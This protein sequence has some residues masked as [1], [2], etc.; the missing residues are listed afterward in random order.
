MS[1]AYFGR[2]W[3][4]KGLL[5]VLFFSIIALT[6]MISLLSIDKTSE[7]FP[8]DGV[9]KH[10]LDSSTLIGGY[11]LSFDRGALSIEETR[12]SLREIEVHTFYCNYYSPYVLDTKRYV[13]LF[14]Y[15]APNYLLLDKKGMS[16]REIETSIPI[17]SLVLGK[18]GI[19]LV[20]CDSS[21]DS[22]LYNSKGRLMLKASFEAPICHAALSDNGKYVAF[23]LLS[24]NQSNHY[25]CQIFNVKTGNMIAKQSIASDAPPVCDY[26]GLRLTLWKNN[27]SEK[28]TSY[29]LLSWHD[30]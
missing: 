21:K 4:R 25:F 1:K 2:I 30:F 28:I 8:S 15:G 16:W 22:F 14:E 19:A 18:N 6:A 24:C 29:Y 13:A 11:T 7:T 26:Q 17:S 12:V 23:I 3:S 27:K 5:F 20:W 9:P 10:I